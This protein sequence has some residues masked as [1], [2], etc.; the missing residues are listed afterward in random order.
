M[1]SE[2][3]G[4]WYRHLILLAD[5]LCCPYANEAV[6]VCRIF[7]SALLRLAL[8]ISRWPL[9]TSIAAPRL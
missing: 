6:R 8:V 3:I 9:I 1:I 4:R 2:W 7:R 5:E